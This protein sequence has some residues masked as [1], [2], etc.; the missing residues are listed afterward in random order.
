MRICLRIL[1][2]I[3]LSIP[4]AGLAQQKTLEPTAA[5]TSAREAANLLPDTPVANDETLRMDEATAPQQGADG[6]AHD[7]GQ[8]SP[9]SSSPTQAPQQQPGAHQDQRQK[10]REQI[11]EQ[12][13]QRVLGIIPAFNTSYRNDAVSLTS[14]EKMGLAFRSAI[15]P[16]AFIPPFFVAG[17]SELNG[18]AGFGWG[19]EGY[20]KRTGAAYLDSFDARMIGKGILPSLLHQD[21]R[22]FRRG[23]GSTSRRLLYAAGTI[24]MC[25][26][27]VSQKWEP[28]YSNVGGNLLSGAISIFYYPSDHSGVDKTIT[29]ALVVTAE[30]AF[31]AMF[32]EFWPDLSR[33]F[34]HRDPTRGLDAEREAQEKANQKTADQ[35]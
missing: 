1:S 27:D 33:K 2:V 15:D 20:F 17:L 23:Y 3:S 13:K 9:Q 11:K 28:N 4:L 34:L 6:S 25:K 18:N 31:G 26:H 22:Y 29:N 5:L 32:Q 14:K 16:V 12:E 21:P 35:K 19:P 30:G 7:F 24:V 8:S 10:A